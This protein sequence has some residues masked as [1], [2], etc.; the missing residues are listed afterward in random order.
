MMHYQYCTWIKT[1]FFVFFGCG[2]DAHIIMPGQADCKKR[3]ECSAIDMHAH[4]MIQ[5]NKYWRT[6]F[7]A[8]C[9]MQ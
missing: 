5:T 6:F 4:R 9:L 2:I 1:F 8:Q 7:S 3:H